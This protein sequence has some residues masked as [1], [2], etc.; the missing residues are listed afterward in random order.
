MTLIQTEVDSGVRY[1]SGDA[2]F[3]NH[4]ATATFEIRG[5]N[6]VDCASNPGMVIEGEAR[7]RGATFLARGNEPSWALEIGHDRIE[8][9]T[10]LGTRRIDFPFRVP[11][12]AGARTMYRSFAGTQELIVV[13]DR[14][15]CND[16]MSGEAFDNTVAV[17]FEGATLYG[18]GRAPR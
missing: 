17:T 10:E 18:C 6:Y 2:V 12:V 8:L 1:A 16:T 7:R 9:A 5:K 13:I 3:W 14:V 4:G 15:Q 11:T